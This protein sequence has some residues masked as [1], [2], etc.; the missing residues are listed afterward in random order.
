M[1]ADEVRA[2]MAAAIQRVD[3]DGI[4]ITTD[5]ARL[6][7]RWLGRL[8]EIT[9]QRN[10]CPPLGLVELQGALTDE[11]AADSRRR[12]QDGLGARELVAFDHEQQYV[13]PPE[14]A[15]ELGVS[16]DTVRWHFRKGNL[17]GR[18]FGRQLMVT[19]ASVEALKTRLSE[20]RGA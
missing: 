9:R 17:D 2:R 7:V 5:V 12:E 18:K 6:L 20:Q 4:L 15:A 14:A 16:A 3:V 11:C 8:T 19:A 13:W 10:G 1:S